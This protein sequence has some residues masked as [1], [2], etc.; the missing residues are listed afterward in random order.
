M[1]SEQIAVSSW[2]A[3]EVEVVISG[4]GAAAVVVDLLVWWRWERAGHSLA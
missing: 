1:S 4:V 2:L 3:S